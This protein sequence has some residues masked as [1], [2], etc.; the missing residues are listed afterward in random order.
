[1]AVKEKLVRLIESIDLEEQALYDN[2]S[3]EERE[4]EG[5]ADA[6]SPKDTLAHIAAWKER[7][8]TNLAAMARGE[9]RVGYNDFEAVN[10]Q[11]FEVYRDW[12]W[13]EV[14]LKAEATNLQLIEAIAARSDTELEAISHAERKVW[15]SIAGT[16]YT[17]PVI[18]LGQI[19]LDRGDP[20][21]ATDLQEAGAEAL[22]ELSESPQW[23]GTVRYNLA[24][25][26][27]LMGEVERAIDGLREA[28][29]L[30]PGLTEW[31]KEDPDFESIRE[32]PGYHALYEGE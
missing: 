3:I 30:N 14:L 16:G 8:A 31:S 22:Q 2:L 9:P 28:L 27:A 23:Q 29:Q 32:E 6:W 17:H 11:D 4:A 15:Q 26:Y 13:S 7:E 19:Y 5:K 18:H 24:C 20:G 12:S 10:A 1:M 21:Y 25:H